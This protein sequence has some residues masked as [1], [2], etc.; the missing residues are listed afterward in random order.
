MREIPSRNGRRFA[1]HQ[2]RAVTPGPLIKR[3]GKA[4][5]LS[6]N[7]TAVRDQLECPG[8]SRHFG[9]RPAASDLPR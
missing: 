6:P 2:T 9:D 5:L 7:G 1:A 8:Q 3:L 4:K